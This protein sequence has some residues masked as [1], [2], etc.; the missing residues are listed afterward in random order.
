MIQTI[1]DTIAKYKAIVAAGVFVLASGGTFFAFGDGI[2]KSELPSVG[3]ATFAQLEQKTLESF[4]AIQQQAQGFVQSDATNWCENYRR[5]HA[6]AAAEVARHPTNA[7]A[8]RD[9]AWY[10]YQVEQWCEKAVNPP[11]FTLPE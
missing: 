8:I 6:E 5:W 7:T 1:L 2:Y 9:E 10:K 11:T 4:K 3:K